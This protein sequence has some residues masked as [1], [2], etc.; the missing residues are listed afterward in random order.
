MRKVQVNFHEGAL[1]VIKRLQEATGGT[2]GDVIRD[3]LGL[4][5]WAREQQEKGYTIGTIKKGK[6]VREL[7]LPF[8]WRAKLV[9]KDAA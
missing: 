1:E 3:A 6:A 2:M 5:E 7:I 9:K 4:Y 8:Q